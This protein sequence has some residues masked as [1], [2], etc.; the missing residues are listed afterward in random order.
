MQSF[1]CRWLWLEVVMVWVDVVMGVC[2]YRRKLRSVP[3]GQSESE[4]HLNASK[5]Y[6]RH[7]MEYFRAAT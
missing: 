5:Q 4:H 2:S 1:R 7:F 3:E 6:I